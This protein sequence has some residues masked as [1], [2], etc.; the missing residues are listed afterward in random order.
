MVPSPNFSEFQNELYLAFKTD[1]EACLY[2]D[3]NPQTLYNYCKDHPEYLEYKETLKKTPNIKAKLN[4]VKSI[5]S[6]DVTDSKRRVERKSRDE[7]SL[8]T[9]EEIDWN[10]SIKW[11]F[12]FKDKTQQE[13]MEMIQEQMK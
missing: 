8:K 1:I 2:A 10:I 4:L 9:V 13:L 6:W 7:F 11:D 3:I 12:N 5:N